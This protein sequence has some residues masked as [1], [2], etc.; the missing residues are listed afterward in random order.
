MKNIP[1]GSSLEQ[2]HKR[3]LEIQELMGQIAAWLE[4]MNNLK[5]SRRQRAYA[6]IRVEDILDEI[7]TLRDQQAAGSN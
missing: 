1:Y 3:A 5:L 2:Y 6:S 7:D 4:A